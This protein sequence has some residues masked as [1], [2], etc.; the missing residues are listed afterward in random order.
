[1]YYNS[2]CPVCNSGIKRQKLKLKDQPI[3]WHDIHLN[4]DSRQDLDVDLEFARER[5]HLVDD[6][7][8]VQVGVDAL[9][10]LGEKSPATSALSK[11]LSVPG[12]HS[13]GTLSYNVFARC[14]YKTNRLLKNW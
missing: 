6:D 3:E 13:I 9:I 8:E 1:M 7:G 14:L 11:V 10:A 12:L 2:A 5:L 4:I